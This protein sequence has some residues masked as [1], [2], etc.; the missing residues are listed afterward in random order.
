LRTPRA[1]PPRGQIPDRPTPEC[2][3]IRKCVKPRPTPWR[4]IRGKLRLARKGRFP[5]AA[6]A[7]MI[8]VKT[9]RGVLRNM[10]G[11]M[12]QTA[13]PRRSV[14]YLPGANA[15]A[16]SKAR[17][18]PADAV[19]LDL[20]DSVPP[21]K[22][23]NARALVADALRQ[24]GFGARETVVRINGFDT[25]W[26]A[27]DIAAVVPAAP[28]AILLPKVS[29]SDDVRRLRAALKAAS[30]RPTV[31]IWAMMETPLAILNAGAI[32]ATAAEEGPALAALAIGASDLAEATRTRQVPGRWTMLPWLSTCVA[33]GRA[34]DVSVIDAV[35]ADFRDAEGFRAECEQGRDL[36]MD[37]KAVIHPNQVATCNE[38]FSPTADEIA[39]ARLILAAFERKENVDKNAIAIDGRMVERFH[40]RQARQTVE[41][42]RAIRGAGEAERRS[43]ERR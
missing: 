5:I 16:F 43:A 3:L 13:R 8:R 34:F 6:N 11:A 18:I 29:R 26:A 1:G 40:A 14:L 30:A 10:A 28:D 42:A 20:E 33:A 36:G 19:I 7:P 37:G 27:G 24:G 31:Q 4:T 2:L 23:E 35:Y 41:I 12:P 38:V 15:R 22:K 39:W 17:S 32:A 21:E 9:G 25:P